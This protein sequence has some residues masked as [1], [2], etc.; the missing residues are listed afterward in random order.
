[1]LIAQYI[2]KYITVKLVAHNCFDPL[3]EIIGDI[4]KE[5]II[6]L[7]NQGHLVAFDCECII[8]LN[9]TGHILGT[10]Y[11]A[12]C[13]YKKY[14]GVLEDYGQ[15]MLNLAID[16]AFNNDWDIYEQ[17]FKSAV[18]DELEAVDKW[19]DLTKLEVA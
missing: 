9:E 3:D 14:D 11:L 4:N 12:A 1:M 2:G 13:I 7:L 17:S 19:T 10:N 5:K 8:T 18:L 15:D 16:N 6:E